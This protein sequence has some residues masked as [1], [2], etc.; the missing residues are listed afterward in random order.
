MNK[1]RIKIFAPRYSDQ[2]DNKSVNDKKGSKE[3]FNS[4]G[5]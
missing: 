5:L 1:T 3:F 4:N 2:F